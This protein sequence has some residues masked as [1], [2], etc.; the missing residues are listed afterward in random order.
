M[1]RPVNTKQDSF[2]VV[3]G[4]AR[5]YGDMGR[6]R[7]VSR[8]GAEVRR[9]EGEGVRVREVSGKVVEEGRGRGWGGWRDVVV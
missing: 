4:K 7:V 8:S 5:F 2:G 6:G 9:E 3:G 1:S